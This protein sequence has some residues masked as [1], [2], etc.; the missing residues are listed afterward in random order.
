[1][2]EQLLGVGFDIHGGGS[3]LVF[4]HHENEAAQTRAA[5]GSELTRLWM[6]NGMIQ[7][8]GEKMAKSVGNVALLHE[9]VD[10]FGAQA[11]VMYLISGHYRQPLAF[12]PGE[13]Q[14]A[15]R[16][17]Q[18]LRDALRRL[19]PG[20]PSPADMA[21][22][23]DAFFDALANDFN[24]PTA[25]AELFE[26]VRE[27]NRRGD[28]VGDADLREMLGVLALGN[29]LDA[30]SAGPD[31]D[32]RR[33]A[34]EREAARRE[35]DFARADELRDELAARGWEVRDGPAGP[36]LVPRR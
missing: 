36:E 31:E 7:F 11:V 26:W 15:E 21:H 29:L 19:A 9:V 34:D 32:A 6:H 14:D 10:Q 20:E 16:R 23:K 1:M 8:T 25:L 33:L 35:R 5:R 18:R 17:V 22:H 12:S 4:P 13:L 30:D 24:T 3:D 27:A 2:A 28:G